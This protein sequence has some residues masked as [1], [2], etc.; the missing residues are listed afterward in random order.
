VSFLGESK[1]GKFLCVVET[2]RISKKHFKENSIAF[3]L[4]QSL[5]LKVGKF[6]KNEIASVFSL[7]L[8]LESLLLCVGVKAQYQWR[9][10]GMEDGFA[11]ESCLSITVNP[12]EVC[13]IVHPGFARITVFDGYIGRGYNLPNPMISRVWITHSERLWTGYKEN[14]YTLGPEGWCRFDLTPWI[15]DHSV[16]LNYL[17]T[18][19]PLYPIRDQDVALLLPEGIFLFQSGKP[20]LRQILS[21]EKFLLG[22]WK[23]WR[24][25]NSKEVWILAEKGLIHCK[26]NFLKDPNQIRI[27]RFPFPSQR[28]WDR[29]HRMLI[30]PGQILS[31]VGQITNDLRQRY[32]VLF[33]NGRWSWFLSPIPAIRF[34]WAHVERGLYWCATSSDVRLI[35]SNGVVSIPQFTEVI[36]PVMDVWSET[37]GTFYLATFK[38]LWRAGLALWH[39]PAGLALWNAPVFRTAIDS[40]GRL[41]FGTPSSLNVYKP[42]NPYL[43][44]SYPWP[45]HLHCERPEDL[46]MGILPNGQLL[47]ILNKQAGIFEPSTKKHRILSSIPQFS[48]LRVLGT[49]PLTKQLIVCVRPNTSKR[50]GL[51]LAR[52]DGNKIQLL[53]DWPVLPGTNSPVFI[54]RMLDG[55]PLA[56]FPNGVFQWNGQKWIP[57]GERK[58]FYG[59]R[60]LCGLVLPDGRLWVGSTT[61]LYERKEGR[62]RLVGMIHEPVYELCQGNWNEIWAATAAGVFRFRDGQILNFDRSEGLPVS[63]V[64]TVTLLPTHRVGIGTARGWVELDPNVDQDPPRAFHPRIEVMDWEG[65][66]FGLVIRLSG[67]D[68]WD[69]TKPNRLLYSWRVDQGAWSPFRQRS[70][71][72]VTHL[73]AGIHTVEVQAMD[74]AGNVQIPPITAQIELTLPWYQEPR[75]RRIVLIALLAVLASLAIAVNRHLRLRKSYAEVERRVQQRTEE[76]QKAAEVLVHTRKM[77]AL[78][79]L[80]AGIAHDFNNILS[81]IRGSAQ[82]I[83]RRPEDPGRTRHQVQ[84]IM[85][86]V[87]QAASLIRSLL[88]F[89]RPSTQE[90]KIC[91]LSPL[92]QETLGL[93]SEPFR[94]NIHIVLDL[95]AGLPPVVAVPDHLRQ[96]LLN[97]I[98]N[99]ADAMDGKGTIRICARVC[100]EAPKDCPLP[101]QPA[102][103]YVALS[104]EDE[105]C[106]IPPEILSRIFEPFFT[107]KSYSARH[108]TGL[109]LYTVYEFARQMGAGLHVES[110]VARGTRFTV[111]LR[112]PESSSETGRESE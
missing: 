60:L 55:Q 4:S 22:A 57:I 99:A 76:L 30:G 48:L 7:L 43:I 88:V 37:N 83:L 31:F 81:V 41:W 38:R 52:Y 2:T 101:P 15:L 92:V 66:E 3:S 25:M 20:T 6:I 80:A 78:G 32:V 82:L 56:V 18:T 61:G 27:E 110:H 63:M 28:P 74:R 45:L 97:L 90:A 51:R 111:Y 59:G 94:R 5:W 69:F 87:D 67:K 14:L 26:G 1:P 35:R 72:F 53:L 77:T 106:G 58:D 79:T 44:Q 24:W 36:G 103:Q 64:Y 112:C 50:P 49:D 109:G 100:R 47:W 12:N 65:G 21:S 39:P 8:F 102:R 34:V 23:E 16:P 29:L 105:G 13:C 70:I 85:Q 17:P 10:F 54:D 19:Y 40:E 71:A 107:T 68:R 9:S 33:Q 93:L 98:L 46:S 108:G 96:I 62:W 42:E 95:P 89:S 84:R 104:V 91:H 86:A 75:F 11:A 73:R